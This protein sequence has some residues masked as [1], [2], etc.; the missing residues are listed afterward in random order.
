MHEGL[1]ELERRGSDKDRRAVTAL[2]R[3][4]E[5]LAAERIKPKFVLFE[6]R[7]Y[8]HTTDN[9]I[10][11]LELVWTYDVVQGTVACSLE[12]KDESRTSVVYSLGI[13]LDL[14][15]GLWRLE[16]LRVGDGVLDSPRA[17]KIAWKEFRFTRAP[18][19]FEIPEDRIYSEI[20]VSMARIFKNWVFGP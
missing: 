1:I 17:R 15:S 6:N 4:E 13:K 2:R 20:L 14:E 5:T 9:L 7:K 10:L 11:E 8:E 16:Y 18:A 19:H 12:F 3:I